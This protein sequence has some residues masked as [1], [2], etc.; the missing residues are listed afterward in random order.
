MFIFLHW[1]R[2]K[3][4][5]HNKKIYVI[6]QIICVIKTNVVDF[7][8]KFEIFNYY[9]FKQCL[10]TDNNS[11]IP[12][13]Y[14]KKSSESSEIFFWKLHLQQF[15]WVFIKDEFSA[16]KLFTSHFRYYPFSSRQSLEP[17]SALQINPFVL[18]APFLYPLKASESAMV[19]WC[20]Q[21]VEKGCIETKWVNSKWCL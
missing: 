16:F 17:G 12:V 19:F 4:H 1:F 3:T 7:K 6:S 13:K 5:L 21:E 11:K 8:K 9:I 18:N 2:L 14:S 20:F 10:L 15:F